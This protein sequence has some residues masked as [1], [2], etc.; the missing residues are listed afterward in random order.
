MLL[1]YNCKP[2]HINGG[3]NGFC[4]GAHIQKYDIR[5]IADT[6]LTDES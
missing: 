3:V 4:A 1:V 5:G 6:E 2:G